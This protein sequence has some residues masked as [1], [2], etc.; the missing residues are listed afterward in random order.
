M[1]RLLGCSHTGEH[2]VETL[3]EAFSTCKEISKTCK[4]TVKCFYKMFPTVTAPLV[5][6]KGESSWHYV[7][8]KIQ[9]NAQL[10]RFLKHSFDFSKVLPELLPITFG[11]KP[12]NT[13]DVAAVQC[14]ALKGDLPMKV[15]WFFND[16]PITTIEN[17]IHVV[18]TSTRISQLTIEAVTAYHRGI[19]RCVAENR[20]GRTEHE[21]ELRVNGTMSTE[22]IPSP[23]N[24]LYFV[25][26]SFISIA[27]DELFCPT[28]LLTFGKIF[29]YDLL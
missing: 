15:M 18:M 7:C 14:M 21:A 3:L 20:A 23:T 11:D 12:L 1:L 27:I 29:R 28:N 24:S 25:F 26:D 5:N 8:Q 17:G 22:I 6:C 16:S 10:S 9:N 4:F 13:D 2:L 19:Y